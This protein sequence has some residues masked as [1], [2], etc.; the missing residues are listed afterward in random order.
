[1]VVPARQHYEPFMQ[2]LIEELVRKANLSEDQA[3]K[4]ADV[5]KSFVGS[6]VPEPM[7]GAVE[8]A[9][10]GERVSGT[11]KAAKGF[12]GGKMKS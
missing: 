3:R 10:T 9:F 2:P 12:F 6:R 11:A 5:V 7:K 8:N 4:A 1:M